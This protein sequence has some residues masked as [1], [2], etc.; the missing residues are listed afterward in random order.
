MPSSSSSTPSTWR[1]EPKYTGN[2]CRC[3]TR[4][5]SSSWVNSSPDRYR[6]MSS[7]LHRAAPSPRAS[8]FAISTKPWP[9]RPSSCLSI[10]SFPSLGWSILL[11][12]RKTGTPAS[13]SSCHRVSVWPWTPSA[14]LT[15]RMAQSST[16]RA[17]S[18]SAEKSTCP[19]VSTR[20]SSKSPRR[21]MACLA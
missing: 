15:T 12:K 13:S 20:V 7:S 8:G 11:T 3:T 9:S 5:A 14:A 4:A 16:C 1:A 19:G 17:R 10:A 18:V 6:S 2:S 21:K